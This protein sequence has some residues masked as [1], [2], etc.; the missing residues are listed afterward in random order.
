MSN[1]ENGSKSKQ[2]VLYSVMASVGAILG[3]PGYELIN[4]PRPDPFTGKDA[5]QIEIRLGKAIVATQQTVKE[6]DQEHSGRMDRI[7]ARHTS[8]IEAES[9]YRLELMER[10][11]T[12]ERALVDFERRLEVLEET[13][14]RWRAPKEIPQR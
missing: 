4:P 2:I 14:L 8:L 11:A 13:T 1:G 10:V 12:M 7:D 5:K 9:R 3:G 6:L